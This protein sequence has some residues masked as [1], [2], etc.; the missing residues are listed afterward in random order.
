MTDM[1]RHECRGSMSAVCGCPSLLSEPHG[2]KFQT[3]AGPL[4]TLPGM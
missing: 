1:Q 3:M 2:S 4:D